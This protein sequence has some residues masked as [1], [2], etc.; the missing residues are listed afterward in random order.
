ME[1]QQKTRTDVDR[2]NPNTL[3]GVRSVWAVAD[4]VLQN[5]RF[6][7]S[8]HERRAAGTRST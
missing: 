6:A 2:L 4:L 5:L 3:L 1:R 8:V 7:K